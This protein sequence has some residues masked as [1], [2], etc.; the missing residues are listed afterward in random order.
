MENNKVHF[1]GFNR[2]FFDILRDTNSH[3]Y[4]MT[5]FGALLGLIMFFATVIFSLIIMFQQKEIDHVILIEIIGFILT[6]LGFKN[7]FGINKNNNVTETP[8]LN[9]NN[10]VVTNDVNTK[11]LLTEEN[12]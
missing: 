11:Q 12:K 9:Q 6:L 4:S 8:D 2:I 3:K 10:N 7:N 1:H 5:K